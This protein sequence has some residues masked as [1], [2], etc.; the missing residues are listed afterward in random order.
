MSRAAIDPPPGPRISQH[1]PDRPLLARLRRNWRWLPT[2]RARVSNPEPV[3]LDLKIGQPWPGDPKRGAAIAAGEVELAGVLISNPVPFW[4]PPGAAEEWVASWHGFAWLTDLLAA[5]AAAREAGRNFVQ[6]WLTEQI[7]SRSVAWRADVLGTRVFA[8]IAHFDE[9]AGK[10]VAASRAVFTSLARQYRRLARTAAREP[11]GAPALRALKGWIA[12]A[13]ALHP[14]APRLS[15]PLMLLERQISAQFFADGGHRSRSPSVQLQAL[16]DLV[17]IRALLRAQKIAPPA[18][19]QN[20]IERAAP[21][22]RLFRHGDRRLALFHDSFEEDGVVIDLALTRSE[23][24]GE[25]R[26]YAPDSGF[27]RLQAGNSLVIIDTGSRPQAGIASHT[28]ASALA[29]EMSCGRERIIVNCGA[30]RGPKSEWEPLPRTTAAHSV[31]VVADTNSSELRAESLRQRAPISVTCERAEHEGQHWIS[32]SHDGYRER[33]GLIYTRELFLGAEGDDLRGEDRLS[34][35]PGAAFAVRFHL[36]P[37]VEAALIE[38]ETA[39][40]L[41]LPSG[42]RWRLRASGAE[43]SLADSIYLGSGP[44]RKTRQ[45]VL[46]GAAAAGGT[47]VRWALRRE[48]NTAGF[49]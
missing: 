41:R 33:F 35:R 2:F 40:L 15:K 24:R 29:F 46:N 4:F 30:Y 43:L 18:P 20:T 28:H 48:P 47:S 31:L 7:D 13:L 12:G 39:A 37:S 26:S 32:A 23:T 10:D 49:D 34:G 9:I 44:A 36:H 38:G 42:A 21:I 16:Q 14:S 3:R 22:L 5:G 6:S 45:L 17:D 25:V 8:W 1:D 27:A 11:V 19:L